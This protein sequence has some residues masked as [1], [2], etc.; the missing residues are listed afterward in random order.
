MKQPKLFLEPAISIQTEDFNKTLRDLIDS[1]TLLQLA[2]RGRLVKWTYGMVL[3]GRA[4]YERRN[5]V[6]F[7]HYLRPNERPVQDGRPWFQGITIVGDRA[8]ER[9]GR[10]NRIDNFPVSG[11]EPDA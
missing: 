3:R 4:G 9:S 7:L 5:R 10:L 1:M 11:W 2:N 6:M 8:A